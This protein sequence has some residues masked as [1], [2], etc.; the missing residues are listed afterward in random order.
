MLREDTPRRSPLT[1]ALALGLLLLPP[2]AAQTRPE[3]TP[4]PAQL[5]A[6]EVPIEKPPE[7]AQDPLAGEAADEAPAGDEGDHENDLPPI[8]P[9]TEEQRLEQYF[10]LW[11]QEVDLLISREERT[12]FAKLETPYQK[13]AF[14]DRFW[15]SRDP[16]PQTARNELRERWERRIH[17]VKARYGSMDDDRARI[18]LVHG[19]PDGGFQ[20]ICTK[21]F[22]PAEVWYYSRSDEV[23]FSFALVFF[24]PR[25]KGG[26]RLWT[27]DTI[28]VNS[29]LDQAQRCINGDQ[30]TQAIS[31]LRQ[32]GA[33]YYLALRRVI[34]KPKPRSEEWLATFL[35]L[36]TEVPE[37]AATFPAQVDLHFPGRYQSRTVIQGRLEVPVN[38]IQAADLGGYRSYDFALT[39]EVVSGNDLFENFRYKFGF[40]AEGFATDILPLAFQRF[41]RPG[42]YKLILR[43]EDLNG[44]RFFRYETDLS[45]PRMEAVFEAPTPTDPEASRLFA[46][47]TAAIQ[48]G[49]TSIK[50]IPPSSELLTGFVRFDT[51]AIG[52]EIQKVHFYLDDQ[53]VLTKNRPPYNVEID[54]GPFPRLQEL[55]V[56]AENGEGEIVAED[57][58]LVNS[59]GNRFAVQLTEPRRGQQYA[60]SLLARA[61]VEVPEGRSL[62]RV[63]FYLD[64]ALVATLYQEP[65]VQPIQLPKG[66]QVSYVRTVAYLPDGNSTEDLVFINAPKYLEEVDVQFVELYTS[67]LDRSGRPVQ[68]LGQG[69]FKVYED[70]QPQQLRRFEKV[71][72]LPIHVGVL[73]DNSGS[74]RE[75]LDHARVAAL[76]FF[77]EAITPRD[78]AAIITF[79]R[80]PNLSVKLTNDMRILGGGLA[81]LTAEGETALYDSLMFGLYYFTGIKG[82]RALL[83]LSDGRDEGSRFSFDETLEYARRAGV[84]IYTIGLASGGGMERWNLQKLA[85][86]TG[87]RS[88][89]IPDVSQLSE[90][91]TLIQQDLRSQ[92]LLAYQSSNT[93]NSTDFRTIELKM[94][95]NAYTPKTI[96]GYYP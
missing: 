64:E 22:I 27:P 10:A 56:E 60:E 9:L 51:L 37:G 81:G 31:Q 90:I 58:F 76:K 61:E 11:L 15:R 67:V 92:Y 2:L 17:E 43:L 24:K 48:S 41:L 74:M 82:Q 1:L 91:Y 30:L 21:T 53:R 94:S 16:Y 88:F 96:S 12:F 69:D 84:T 49:E 62:E 63:E 77:Q 73:L 80:V 57:V 33:N 4:E 25:G 3:E 52:E 28:G 72:N 71:E 68:G 85:D 5:D 93:T 23:D 6:A 89:F 32:A 95:D 29:T 78:R 70:G 19:P 86:E 42:D 75:S 20:V 13:Q 44:E 47:A 34:A 8:D 87:G 40:P 35:S 50:L 36:S 66:G 83:L 59:G 79:N 54:L 18:Y 7:A 46:E 45:V 39:G 55:K 65:F 14:I 38:A 26:A